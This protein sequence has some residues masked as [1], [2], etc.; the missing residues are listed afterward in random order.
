[1]EGEIRGLEKHDTDAQDVDFPMP[2]DT[3][4][5]TV[6]NVGSAPGHRVEI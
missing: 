5:E 3:V 6:D 1:V 2:F 4:R